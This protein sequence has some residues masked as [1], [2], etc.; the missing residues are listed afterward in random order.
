M[1]KV[2]KNLVSRIGAFRVAWRDMAPEA[3]F[4]GMS[5]AQFEEATQSP[6]RL[7]GEIVALERQWEGKKAERL[8]ADSAANE[9]LDLVVNSVRGTPGF[10]QDCAL[11]R[12]LGYIRKSDRKSGLTRKGGATTQDANAA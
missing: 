2:Q 4:A 7:R 8:I 5:L 3:T 6:M 12:A 9:L 1:P 11:Y 10:G